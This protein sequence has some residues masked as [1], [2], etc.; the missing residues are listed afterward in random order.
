MTKNRNE[1]PFSMVCKK[2]E[3][4]KPLIFNA[5]ESNGFAVR[6]QRVFYGKSTCL[7]R[8]NYVFT[9]GKQRV[10]QGKTA[11][12]LLVTFQLENVTILQ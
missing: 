9:R 10:Y 5:M 6:K 7:L 8:E 11:Y 2:I 1:T 3:L 4:C 12:F